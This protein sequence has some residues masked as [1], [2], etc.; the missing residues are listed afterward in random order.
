MELMNMANKRTLE[1]FQIESSQHLQQEAP[2]V[3]IKFEVGS[4]S[5]INNRL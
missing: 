3:S 5:E 4:W 2:G 1:T